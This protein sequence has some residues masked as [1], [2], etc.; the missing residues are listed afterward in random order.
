MLR[1]S[2]RLR[3]GCMDAV[4]IHGILDDPLITRFMYSYKVRINV[5]IEGRMDLR[6]ACPEADRTE[7]GNAI[8]RL[9]A[10][11]TAHA[12]LGDVHV[13]WDTLNFTDL[14]E[15]TAFAARLPEGGVENSYATTQ[16][17]S[18]P[19]GASCQ[20]SCHFP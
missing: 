1:L 15:R 14:F 19:T 13:L 11:L 20:P 2:L 4:L 3:A 6:F 16:S 9:A 5:F 17:L 7:M 18:G 10:L 8:S 12:D